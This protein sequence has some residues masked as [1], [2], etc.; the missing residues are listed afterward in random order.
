MGKPIDFR[1]R[2]KVKAQE[3]EENRA[4]GRKVNS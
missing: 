2:E 1:L 4:I 3:T